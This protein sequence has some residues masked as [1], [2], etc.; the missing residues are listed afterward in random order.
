MKRHHC[1][2]SN[3]M[4]GSNGWDPA[5]VGMSSTA[6]TPQKAMRHVTLRNTS[7]SK[8]ASKSWDAATAGRPVWQ[9]MDAMRSKSIGH[10]RICINSKDACSKDAVL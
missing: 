1:H 7:K 10:S 6:G 3:R 9:A 8:D 5:T 2:T 4:D